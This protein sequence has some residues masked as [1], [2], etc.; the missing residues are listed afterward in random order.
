MCTLLR[1]GGPNNAT[2]IAGFTILDREHIVNVGIADIGTQLTGGLISTVKPGAVFGIFAS[3]TKPG[4]SQGANPACALT[5]DNKTI[6]VGCS[7][8]G[9]PNVSWERYNNYHAAPC[10]NFT[11]SKLRAQLILDHNSH[12]R[13]EPGTIIRTMLDC[14]HN[15]ALPTMGQLL[16]ICT[17]MQRPQRTL[18]GSTMSSRGDLPAWPSLM[19]GL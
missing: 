19:T 5:A 2:Y 4:A 3:F 16:N 9:W 13:P 1:R 12:K 14:K 7:G 10:V 17:C 8:G 11:A 15:A 6:P 18:S